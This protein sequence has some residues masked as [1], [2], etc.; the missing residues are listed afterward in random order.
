MVS[1]NV[2]LALDVVLKPVSKVNNHPLAPAVDLAHQ[3]NLMSPFREVFL[4]NTER[5]NPQVNALRI[6]VTIVAKCTLEVHGNV[7]WTS[8]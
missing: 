4:I 6:M 7:M 2:F 3:L 1:R 8:S 5:I